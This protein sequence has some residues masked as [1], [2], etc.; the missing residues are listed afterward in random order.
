MPFTPPGSKQPAAA[1]KSAKSTSSSSPSHAK[2]IDAT[3]FVDGPENTARLQH[4]FIAGESLSVITKAVRDCQDDGVGTIHEKTIWDSAAKARVDNPRFSSKYAGLC[5]KDE[6]GEFITDVHAFIEAVNTTVLLPCAD[7]FA[8]ITY[9]LKRE[10]GK[11]PYKTTS[12]EDFKEQLKDFEFKPVEPS[13]IARL[14]Y[15][16]EFLKEQAAAGV[17]K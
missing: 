14:T 4:K 15:I 6:N 11:V 3:V 10:I 5:N 2:G 7:H 16:E 8:S 1:N 17:F 9:F 12:F 13:V